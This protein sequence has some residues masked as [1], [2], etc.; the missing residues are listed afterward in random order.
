MR[1][2]QSW[3]LGVIQVGEYHWHKHGKDDEFGRL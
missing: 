2:I 1:I 3:R